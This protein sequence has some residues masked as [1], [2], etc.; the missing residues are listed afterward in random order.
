MVNK[1]INRACN[2]VWNFNRRR[3]DA[4]NRKQCSGSA[5]PTI[6]SC[7]CTGGVMYHELGWRFMS[8][9]VNLYMRCEDF[10]KFCE[11][12]EYYLSLPLMPYEGAV[13][14]DYPLCS[15]GDLTL[16]MVHYKSF[17]EAKQKWEAR[18]SRVNGENIRIIATDRDGCTAELKDRFEKLPYPKVM[19]V[20]QPDPEHPSCFYIR[21]F[22]RDGQVGT[23]VDHDGKTGGRRYYDQFR[24]VEFLTD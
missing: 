19:F 22:E 15:L 11:R 7:N 24:W 4:K 18:A 20:H 1:I 2:Y 17:E 3:R 16:Y 10:I 13:T 14:R 6:F 8:P 5:V 23:L 12:W 21:G 9:T